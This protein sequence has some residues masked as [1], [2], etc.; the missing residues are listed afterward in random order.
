[1]YIHVHMIDIQITHILYMIQKLAQTLENV[2]CLDIQ[3]QE[4]ISQPDLMLFDFVYNSL[5]AYGRETLNF[6]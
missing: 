2:E 6:S 3:R 5:R 4:F 1:M